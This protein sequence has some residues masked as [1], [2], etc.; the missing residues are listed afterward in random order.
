MVALGMTRL[1]A[2]Q[3]ATL[4]AAHLLGWS[5]RVGTLE[6]GKFA[7]LI[8]IEG[9]PLSDKAGTRAR[10]TRREGWRVR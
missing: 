10:P 8:A 7:D 5:D 6:V 1:Q 3:G 4:K 2:I 9:D